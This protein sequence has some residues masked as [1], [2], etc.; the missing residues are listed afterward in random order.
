MKTHWGTYVHDDNETW[1]SISSQQKFG[2]AGRKTVRTVRWIINGVKK[3]ASVSAL[4]TALTSLEEAY[5]EDQRDLIFKDNDGN[6]TVHT[7]F[8]ADTINGTKVVRFWYPPGTTALGGSYGSGTEYNTR[9]TFQAIIEADVLTAEW[10]IVRFHE[11]LRFI[12]TGGRKW[13]L[14]GALTGPVQEQTLQQQ[15]E[16][17]A[18]QSGYAV[19]L[20]LFPSPPAPIFP[21]AVDGPLVVEELSS[22]FT[23]GRVRNTN[24]G[25]RWKYNYKSATPM[26]GSPTI[27]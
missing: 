8:N 2:P 11:S 20:L 26:T 15:T 6:N 25:I 27:I 22:P 24:F 1:H 5:A 23:M 14:M 17:R 10:N 12:G 16:Y 3:A 9:R 4:T 7:V 21:A 18:V 19:G 13:I